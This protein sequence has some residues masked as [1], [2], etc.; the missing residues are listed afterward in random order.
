MNIYFVCT[1]NICRSPMAAAILSSKNLAHLTVKSAGVY[2]G[3][4]ESMSH[5]AQMT[6]AQNNMSVAHRASQVNEADIEWADIILTMTARHKQLLV[7]GFRE[8]S[9]KIYTLNEYI[10]GEQEDVIDPYGGDLAMY[11]QTYM[12]LSAAIELL[13][14]KLEKEA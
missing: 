9:S 5:Y 11:E 4:G 12:E 7:Q 13:I 10:F 8:A 6:L 3:E 2:A 14:A 1:G